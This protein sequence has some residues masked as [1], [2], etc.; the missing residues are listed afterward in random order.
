MSVCAGSSTDG[1]AGLA[2]VSPRNSPVHKRRFFKSLER[3]F[4]RLCGLNW[5]DWMSAVAGQVQVDRATGRIGFMSTQ[6]R[7]NRWR[8]MSCTKRSEA[9]GKSILSPNARFGC[10]IA[11]GG[12]APPE[13]SAWLATNSLQLGYRIVQLVQHVLLD[14]IFRQDLRQSWPPS[15]ASSDAKIGRSTNRGFTL[16]LSPSHCRIARLHP[17][18]P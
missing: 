4:N 5:G 7:E 13:F 2:L 1:L 10:T 16:P 12:T 15:G 3:F 18:L 14:R 11:N 17:D 6:R 8:R 9:S